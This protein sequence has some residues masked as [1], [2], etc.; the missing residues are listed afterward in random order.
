M[1]HPMSKPSFPPVP[2]WKPS[3]PVDIARTVQTFARY[4]NRKRSFVVFEHGTCVVV[5]DAPQSIE[6]EAKNIL[7]RVYKFHP[8]F[9]PQAMDDGHFSVSY[10]Q[11]A[12]SIV[13]ADEFEAN[14]QYIE[15]HHLD[16]VVADEVL[17]LDGKP[18]RFDD[19]GKVGLFARARMF[20]DAQAPRVV[21]VWRPPTPS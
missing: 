14:R 20:M 13:F 2:T 8:D 15:D 16:G 5:P 1:D 3:I 10:S 6:L 21:H 4:T 17:L 12:F 11:P 9:N 7:D 19:R 18:N